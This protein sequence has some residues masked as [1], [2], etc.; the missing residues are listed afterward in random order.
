MKSISHKKVAA[1]VAS[2]HLWSDLQSTITP[3]VGSLKVHARDVVNDPQSLSGFDFVAYV[4]DH[5]SGTEIDRDVMDDLHRLSADHAV[6]FIAPNLSFPCRVALFDVGVSECIDCAYHVGFGALFL[7]AGIDAMARRAVLHEQKA[8]EAVHHSS[9]RGKNAEAVDLKQRNQKLQEFVGLVA[10]DLRVPLDNIV[11]LANYMLKPSH[12]TDAQAMAH[13]I[14]DSGKIALDL[15]NDLLDLTAIETGLL[16]LDVEPFDVQDF[17]RHVVR[18][19]ET[20]LRRKSLS[21]EI[22]VQGT[23][24]AGGDRKRIAQ[25]VHNLLSNAIKFTPVG[26]T[27]TLRARVEQDGVRIEIA[28]SGIGIKTDSIPRL[29]DKFEKV[30]TPGTNGEAGTGFGLP[31]SQEIVLAHGSSLSVESSHE[32]GTRFWFFLPIAIGVGAQ[33]ENEADSVDS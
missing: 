1:V 9:P 15:V 33:Q 11:A 29:F 26:G 5:H 3:L 7:H 32:T 12:D 17:L 2:D 24:V 8:V 4:A 18:L 30:S 14:H 22:D 20:P 28:D 21:L 6:V 31:L 13:E 10:H 23:P 19:H 27:I 16:V 25:V